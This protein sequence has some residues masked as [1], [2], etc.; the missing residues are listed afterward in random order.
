MFTANEVCSTPP[1]K[2]VQN[3]SEYTMVTNSHAD[4]SKAGATATTHVPP[5]Q[6]VEPGIVESSQPTRSYLNSADDLT[7]LNQGD[8]TFN[9]QSQSD[10]YL[11]NLPASAG[12]NKDS[13]EELQQ[14]HAQVLRTFTSHI[15]EERTEDYALTPDNN[16]S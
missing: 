8:K 16:Q 12:N 4:P 7:Y 11:A 5:P 6:A 2:D 14:D 15:P 1:D 9:L 10:E 13:D 3:S